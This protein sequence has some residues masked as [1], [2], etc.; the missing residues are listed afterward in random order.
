MIALFA[1]VHAAEPVPILVAET[2]LEPGSFIDAEDVRVVM[3]DGEQAAEAGL[4][5]V[6]LDPAGS[7]VVQR[8]YAG[9]PLR[10]ERLFHPGYV[11]PVPVVTGMRALSVPLDP[12]RSVRGFD[13]VDV[14]TT[15]GCAA[16]QVVFVLGVEDSQGIVHQGPQLVL[17]QQAALLLLTEDDLAVVEGLRRAGRLGSIRARAEGDV[18]P[19]PERQ[20]SS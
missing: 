8:V 16:V 1:V 7:M 6:A 14:W 9:E 13:V 18:T 2:T 15:E 3:V 19:H 5:D 11:G 20:C 4:Q 12:S 17:P 10:N